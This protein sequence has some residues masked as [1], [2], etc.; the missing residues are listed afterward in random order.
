MGKKITNDIE[1]NV[2]KLIQN[3]S[4]KEV[5]EICKLSITSIRKILI[6]NNI[7]LSKSRVNMSHLSLDVNYFKKIDEPKKAYWLGFICADGYINVNNSKLSINVKDKEILEKFKFDIKSRH[8]LSERII[9]DKRT[10]KNYQQYTLQITNQIFVQNIVSH[11]ITH[12]KT[13]IANFPN[14]Y[15]NLYSYFIAGL[16]DGDGSISLDSKNKRVRCNLISTKEILIFIQNILYKNFDIKFKKFYKVTKNKNN[17]YKIFFYGDNAISFLNYIYQGNYNIFLSRKYNKYINNRY[18][19]TSKKRNQPISVYDENKNKI[20]SF[21][22]IKDAI[23]KLNVRWGGI[24]RSFLTK[25]KY[26]G[27]YWEYN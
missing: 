19:K 5:G 15:E 20:Y 27:Y 14:I 21:K 13:D 7:K 9:F 24:R 23:S 16:F 26:K 1:K 10:N 22:T 12:Q 4:Q 25:K 18:N 6:K 11:G 2:I 17:V 3:H 8:K